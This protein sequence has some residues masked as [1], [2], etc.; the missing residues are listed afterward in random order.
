MA[1]DQTYTKKNNLYFIRKQY[2]TFPQCNLVTNRQE[3]SKRAKLNK[4]PLINVIDFICYLMKR[5]N[6]TYFE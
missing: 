4:T 1:S 5:G 2:G 3:M 6:F